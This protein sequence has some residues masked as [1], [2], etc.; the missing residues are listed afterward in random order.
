MRGRNW[1]ILAS[2]S[3]VPNGVALYLIVPG[4]RGLTDSR[5]NIFIPIIVAPP[6]NIAWRRFLISPS[7]DRPGTELVR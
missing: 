5:M 4:A 7:E 1:R 6:T 2:L 3:E